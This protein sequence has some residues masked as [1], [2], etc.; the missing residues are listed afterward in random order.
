MTGPQDALDP[1][2]FAELFAEVARALHGADDVNTALHRIANVATTVAKCEWAGIARI[3]DRA[4]IVEA[5]SQH[6]D[7]ELIAK[8]QA[9]GGGG[10]TWEAV[11]TGTVVH[12]P[13]L[14]RERRWPGHTRELL[15]V[16]PVRSILAM[17]LSAEGKRLGALTLYS[18]RPAAF[19]AHAIRLASV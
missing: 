10:P 8:I 11:R 17:A 13:D 19:D 12:V 6:S 16:T 3:S 7:G 9:A 5:T 1:L 18:H 4:P 2:E 15:I 14:R